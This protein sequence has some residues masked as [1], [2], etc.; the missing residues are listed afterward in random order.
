MFA[1]AVFPALIHQDPRYFRKGSGHFF[2]R[3][4]YSLST[5][6]RAKN[7]KGQW[8]PNYSNILGN[9]AAGGLANAYYPASD[10]GLGLTLDRALSVLVWGA[11]GSTFI[12]FWPDISSRV[13]RKH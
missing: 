1:G 11:V 2:D 12:E 5:T 6:V 4:L 8:V 13:F 7:D 9:L 10:R 3:V